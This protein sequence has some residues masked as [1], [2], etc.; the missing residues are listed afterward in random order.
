MNHATRFSSVLRGAGSFL[1]HLAHG[2]LLSAGFLALVWLA[3][4]ALQHES[5]GYA[6]TGAA[7]V[8]AAPLAVPVPPIA[9]SSAS[10]A[11]PVAV[12]HSAKRPVALSGE[13]QRVR[14][15]VA[16]RYRVSTRALDPV[17]VAA[18][19]NGRRL[20]IDPL[21][22]VAVIAVESS[23]NPFAESVAGAQGLMQV[24]PRFHM[25]KIGQ[26]RGDDAL[27]DPLLN[28][29]VGSLVLVEGMRRFGSLQEA[30]QY[31]GGALSD[32]EAG[33]A[34]KVFEM[35]RRLMTAAG[36]QVPTDV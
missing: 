30:L 27:F 24:I 25:D 7:D 36:R 11:N 22:I 9:S 28:V 13:M 18:Q 15:Y 4:G 16:R 20:G 29:R 31:Y 5:V 17:F 19:E 3:S 33:Y 34:N 26:G 23:F 10:E 21:L 8:H 35:K 32:P 6:D 2:G 14:D 12:A 1:I